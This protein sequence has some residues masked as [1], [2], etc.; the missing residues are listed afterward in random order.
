MSARGS[1]ANTSS[2]SISTAV[3]SSI[4]CDSGRT[5]DAPIRSSWRRA[6]RRNGWICR[7]STR[8]RASASRPAPPATAFSSAART[9]SS[10]A[11]AIPRSRRRSISPTSPPKVTVVHRRGSFRAE[12]ILHRASR[13]AANVEDHMEQRGR[14]SSRRRRRRARSPASGCSNVATGALDDSAADGVFVAIGHAPAT[15]L[16]RGQLDAEAER[17]CSRRRRVRRR[18]ASRACSPPATS[19]TTCSVRR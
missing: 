18:P 12:K 19:P 6:P 1:R 15:E 14:G 9:S 11:A 17:L 13:G 3:R 8:S 2:R 16:V 7:A 10:S 4:R 5:L